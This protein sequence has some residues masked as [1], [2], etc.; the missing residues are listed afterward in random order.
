MGDADVGQQGKS[1]TGKTKAFLVDRVHDRHGALTKR[2]AADVVDAIFST[3]KSTLVDGKK[4]QIKNFGVF[5]VIAR[6]GRSGVNPSSGEPIYIP[7]HRGLQFRP[8]RQ[9]RDEVETEESKDRS[10]GPGSSGS[11]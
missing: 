9:L 10:A 5:E 1:E 4:V 3:L 6:A 2:E 8:S 11:H 7:P